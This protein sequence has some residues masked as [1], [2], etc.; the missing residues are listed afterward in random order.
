MDIIVWKGLQKLAH[1]RRVLPAESK[2][3]VKCLLVKSG[4]GFSVFL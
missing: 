3:N 1:I 4:D 2:V